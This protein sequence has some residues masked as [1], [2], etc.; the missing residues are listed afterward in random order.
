MIIMII[1]IIMIMIMVIRFKLMN[2]MF[3]G[4]ILQF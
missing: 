3:K 1:L 2:N 4:L